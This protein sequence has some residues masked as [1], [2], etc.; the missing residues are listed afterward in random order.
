MSS[1]NV[2]EKLLAQ[3]EALKLFPN[4]NLVKQL[5]KRIKEKLERLE[6]K[7]IEIVPPIS[8]TINS[9]SRKL[10][11]YHRYL[12]MIRDSFPNLKYGEIRR[13]FTLR[14]QGFEANIPDVVW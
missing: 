9:R 4:N 7:S 14:K 5:R 10:K 13:Q 6:R 2:K 11:K 12:R 1:D 3:L 8:T